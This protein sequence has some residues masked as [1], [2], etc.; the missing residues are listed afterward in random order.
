MTTRQKT[1]G[2]ALRR[3]GIWRYIRQDW[4]L[5][6]LLLLPMAFVLLFKYGSYTGLV[7]AFKDYKI[8]K[9]FA[10]S[11]WVGFDNFVKVFKT[12]DFSRA[13]RNTLLLN[14][15]D[16]IFG[17]PAPILLALAL[18]EIRNRYFKRITQTLLYLPHFLSWVIIGAIAYQIFGLSG[19]V[20]TLIENS[21]GKAI[22]FLQENTHWLVSYVVIGVWQTMG[23]G[24]IVYLAAITSISPELYE[25]AIVDGAN[26]W[27][28]MWSVTLPSIR[29]TIVTLLI[30]N[31]GRIMGGS[32]ERVHSLMNVATT[33]YT[34]TIPVLVYRW[35][36]ES[37][38]YSQATAL[39]LFQSV[40]GLALVLGSDFVAK[41]LGEDGLL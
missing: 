19:I 39:G 20:N 27:Q 11:D 6:L 33:E 23:W 34:Y 10:A 16:L 12:R 21:G 2:R 5:Y 14:G 24:T 7:V 40:I 8:L 36:L 17:F 29:S 4:E 30:M 26:R 37:G 22:P 3:T 1:A 28:Q 38:K 41:R 31:L 32:F 25:A 15:L 13:F 18:N 35:G 9:G